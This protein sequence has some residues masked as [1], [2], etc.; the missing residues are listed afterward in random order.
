[1]SFKQ[2]TQLIKN[3]IIHIDVGIFQG[4]VGYEPST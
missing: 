1:M 3:I 2:R 4:L